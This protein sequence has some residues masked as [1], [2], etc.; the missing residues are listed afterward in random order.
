M[1]TALT[2]LVWCAAILLMVYIVIMIAVLCAWWKD[3]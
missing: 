1:D 3:R 2:V